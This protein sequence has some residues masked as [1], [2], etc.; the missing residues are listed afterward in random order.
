MDC[1]AASTLRFKVGD[2]VFANCEKGWEKGKIIKLWDEGNPYRIELERDR[3][4]VW[5]YADIP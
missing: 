1:K 2:L 3:I 5:G 4:N